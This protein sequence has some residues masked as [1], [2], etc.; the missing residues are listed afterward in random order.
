[1]MANHPG[2]ISKRQESRILPSNYVIP[3]PTAPGG[4]E[5]L[6]GEELCSLLGHWKIFQ[7]PGGH[8]WSSDDLVTA[9]VA[10]CAWK[11]RQ[12]QE[13]DCSTNDE[14]GPIS[15]LDLGC[16][17]GTV[18]M[19]MAWQ[20][21]RATCMG[22]EAQKASV[23]M[24]RR[25]I[26]YNGITNRCT[27]HHGDIRTFSEFGTDASSSSDRDKFDNI[28]GTPPYFPVTFS[29][30]TGEARTK[31]GGLPTCEQSAPARYEFRGGVDIYIQAAKPRLRDAMSRF[32]VVVGRLDINHRRVVET[33]QREELQIL[34]QVLVHGR[35]DK[36]PLF[37]VYVMALTATTTTTTA[38]NNTLVS[39][40]K[41]IKVDR[42]VIRHKGG[43]RTD[44]YIRLMATMGIPPL[45]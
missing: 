27:V 8:R 23:S 31:L 15:C 9:W 17:I 19:M 25:S 32:V 30:D 1:M 43:K 5:P 38:T 45:P 22:I 7:R 33:A 12:A 34:Q 44:Q 28:T 41:E 11:N 3:G 24:A 29:N 39:R 16:G 14:I 10:G 42:L 35:D 4:V 13:T 2:S 20:Y 21:P 18:L 40:E 26:Q 36:P 6:E 37:A